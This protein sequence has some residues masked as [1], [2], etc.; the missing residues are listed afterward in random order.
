MCVANAESAILSLFRMKN[1]IRPICLT[2]SPVCKYR[3]SSINPKK[4]SD[5]LSNNNVSARFDRCE[6]ILVPNLGRRS[7]VAGGYKYGL[8][9]M[10]E[11]GSAVVAG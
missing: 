5:K 1:E 7:V 11:F 3:Y 9:E 8:P 2:C 4:I 6:P 10:G